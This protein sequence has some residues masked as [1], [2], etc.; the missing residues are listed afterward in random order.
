ME[1]VFAIST[2]TQKSQPNQSSSDQT[3]LYFAFCFEVILFLVALL[4][5]L[6]EFSA[7][8][9]H[10]TNPAGASQSMPDTD[11]TQRFSGASIK[12]RSITDSAHLRCSVPPRGSWQAAFY[13]H[14]IHLSNGLPPA[15]LYLLQTAYYDCAITLV[16]KCGILR[17][18]RK[19]DSKIPLSGKYLFVVWKFIHV[20]S[21]SSPLILPSWHLTSVR[22]FAG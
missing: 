4:P 16:A 10:N 20:F 18:G 8:T 22:L 1:N 17:P 12:R 19:Q 7:A 15:T 11:P 3:L 5:C 2:T 14:N 6:Q 13:S 21:P 9:P